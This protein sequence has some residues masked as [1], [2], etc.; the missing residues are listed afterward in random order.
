LD[1][2]SRRILAIM[3]LAQ[4]IRRTGTCLKEDEALDRLPPRQGQGYLRG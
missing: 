2:A 4:T 1:A 3:T